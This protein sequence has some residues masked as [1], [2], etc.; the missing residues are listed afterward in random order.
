MTRHNFTPIPRTMIGFDRLLQ[1]LDTMAGQDEAVPGY[2]PYDI[3]KVDDDAYRI[4]LAV[5][6]FGPDD[7]VVEQRHNTL[8][9]TGGRSPEPSEGYLYRGK[10][11]TTGCCGSNSGESCRRR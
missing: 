3:E 7:L 2:P 6:G 5:A 1:L 4:T 9:V 11:S 10:A 8:V